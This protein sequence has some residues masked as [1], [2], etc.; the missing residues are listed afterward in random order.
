MAIDLE[1]GSPLPIANS[2]TRSGAGHPGVD[3]AEELGLHFGQRERRPGGAP[4]KFG[5]VLPRE[6][7]EAD[8]VPQLI[9]Q[10]RIHERWVVARDGQVHTGSPEGRHRMGFQGREAAGPDVRRGTEVQGDPVADQSLE[11]LR[12]A[13]SRNAMID[14]IGIEDVEGF[15][16]ARGGPISPAWTVKPRPR[17]LAASRYAMNSSTGTVPSMP[18]RARPTMGASAASTSRSVA[19]ASAC[20]LAT[21]FGT[22]A[23]QPAAVPGSAAPS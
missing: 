6:T 18:V 15:G 16:D 10:C 5:E 2:E 7:S 19:S 14:P 8:D 1:R 17:R 13:D 9:V 3:L 11:Q 4:L 23:I 21:V 12:I 22:L 20:L